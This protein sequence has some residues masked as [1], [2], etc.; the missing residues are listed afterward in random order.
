M[1]ARVFAALLTTDSGSLTAAGLAEMLH[2]SP[3][4]ISGAVRF[5]TQLS[6]V[7]RE[8]EPGS[9]RDHYRLYDEVL[10]EI[11]SRRDQILARWENGLREGL[12]AVGSGSPAGARLAETVEFFEFIRA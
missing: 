11:M 8:R 2:V 3:A 10:L 7:T 5:L 12:D 4:A 1:P 9:R 6:L